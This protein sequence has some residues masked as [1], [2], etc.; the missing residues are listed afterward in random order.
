MAD[1][2]VVDRIKMLME[3]RGMK[4]S[5]LA[6]KCEW[7][8][9][10]M[11]KILSGDQKISADDLVTIGVALGTNPAL[12]IS[13]NMSDVEFSDK[14]IMPL[15]SIFRRAC[16]GRKD[17]ER[18]TSLLEDELVHTISQYLSIKD[19]GKTVYSHVKKLRKL[20]PEDDGL[21]SVPRVLITDRREGQLFKNQL[22]IGYWFTEDGEYVYL[23][24]HY[25]KK[26]ATR[27]DVSPVAMQDMREYFRIFTPMGRG[28]DSDERMDFGR[29][30]GELRMMSAGTIFCK[31]YHLDNP[32][33]EDKLKKDLREVYDAY[34]HLLDEA[35]NRVQET[36]E[37][38]YQRQ[39]ERDRK[40]RPDQDST[41]FDKA[42][43]DRIMPVDMTP[44]GRYALRMRAKKIAFEREEY[45]CELDSEHITFI[46]RATDRPY[47]EGH[48]LI[49]YSAQDAFK[50]SL[51][52]DAN[53]CCVCPICQAKLDHA[54]DTERQE[55]LMQLY[56]KHKDMLKTAGI[57]ITPMQLFKLYGMS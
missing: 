27:A 10:K 41:A 43:L 42:D 38:I 39:R 55:L 16:N 25:M 50:V 13:Y 54:S 5:D 57:E 18:Y 35:T 24:I 32:Y 17:V 1:I 20:N 47:M 31:K 8:V 3:Q 44:R 30:N 45:K 51:D 52:V 46:D 48:M 34:L 7:P 9:S 11:S 4:M 49:P 2:K 33:R 22:T 29:S 14:E 28:Y 37:N 21:V 19:S 56:M 15:S 26:G 53:I 12:L 40:E 36:Y 23:A 6:S